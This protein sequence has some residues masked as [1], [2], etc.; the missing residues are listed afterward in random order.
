MKN[1]FSVIFTFLL[2]GTVVLLM[3]YAILNVA[4]KPQRPLTN[5][6]IPQETIDWFR[7][8]INSGSD[9][10][11]IL[12]PDDR[13]PSEWSRYEDIDSMLRIEDELFVIY[14][15]TKD[16][17]VEKSKAKV[18]Q[19]YAHEAIPEG[20]RLMKN[21]PYPSQMNGRKLPI[22]LAKTVDD[23]R[24]I[25]KQLNHGDPGTWS[26]GLY[27]FQY[28]VSGVYTD[29]ILISPKAWTI[30]DNQVDDDSKDDDLKKTLW[31]EMNHFMFFTNWDYTKATKPSL[32]FTEGLAE[33]FA[34]NYERLIS[35]GDHNKFQLTNDFMDGNSEYWVGMSAIM[36]L[37]K[38][39]GKSV[40]SDIVYNSYKNSIDKAVEMR[41]PSENLKSWNTRWHS[42]MK[43]RE[44]KK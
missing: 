16:S 13:D 8:L 5:A 23:Y 18:T 41:N 10:G 14:Y 32:W 43:N 44:Y 21:Y 42:Y 1:S 31:H 22:Y 15:S 39:H 37:E 4:L 30:S 24:N 29:G 36:C 40:V 34:E 9:I 6:D 7:N 35:V 38:M 19:R 11:G 25:C 20:E 27:C 26:I 3:G 17:V 2:Y 33:Y 12:G 28:G